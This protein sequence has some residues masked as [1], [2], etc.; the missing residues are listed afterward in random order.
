M[1]SGLPPQ[2][3]DAVHL[4]DRVE[5]R[6]SL[7]ALPANVALAR[8]ALAGLADQLGVDATRVADMKIALTEACTNVVVH[9]YGERQGPLE[10]TMALEHGRL[11]L[12]V[13]DRGEGLH[14]LPAST[15][16]PPLGFGLA[17]ITSLTDEFGIVGSRRGTA[18]RMAFALDDAPTPP[19]VLQLTD[20]DPA[21]GDAI[22][23]RL[24]GGGHATSVLGRIVSLV[25]A[26]TDFSIDRLSD[27][28]IV[29]DAIAGAA[30]AHVA[31][32]HVRV[33]IDERPGGFDLVVGP[34]VPGG[35]RRL[36]RDT[37]LPGLGCLLERLTDGLEIDV[38]D[39][40]EAELL[41]ARLAAR[42]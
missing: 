26:R 30:G 16:G 28:Q 39:G 4:D 34:L 15:E 36:I 19:L 24:A 33:A 38:L 9:A 35:A 7:P 31:D 1:P 21:P 27:A 6:M 11:V 40:G 25:A 2:P 41:R 5:V 32:G 42:A 13:R 12:T 3:S 17:L 8:Q 14:P 29:S 22:V 10:V 37:E 20:D 18:V 23:L